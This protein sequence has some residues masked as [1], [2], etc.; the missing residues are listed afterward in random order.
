MKKTINHAF[1][2]RSP[3]IIARNLLGYFFIRKFEEG[4][5][6]GRIVETEAYGNQTDLASHA[7]FGVT[8]RNKIMYGDAGVLYVY[9]IYGIFWLTNIICGKNGEPGAVLLRS[10]EIVEGQDIA[11]KLL[12]KSKF[13]KADDRLATGPGKLSLAFGID[14]TDNYTDLIEND[15]IS[16]EKGDP[17]SDIIETQRIGIDYAGISK[18]LPW[19]FY[20]GKSK[21]ISHK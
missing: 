11:R 19:R 4:K 5:V 17:P 7:R 9:S 10:C 12:E 16:L 20:D 8:E 6:V 21:L 15:I 2:E 3:Q 18:E 13:V 14:K 1:F